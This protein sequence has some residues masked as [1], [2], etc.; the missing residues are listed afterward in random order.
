MSKKTNLQ[1]PRRQVTRQKKRENI[2]RRQRISD[3][4]PATKLRKIEVVDNPEIVIKD[5]PIPK[6]NTQLAEK[7]GTSKCLHP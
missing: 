2:L 3:K 4:K 7:V 6:S 5:S 1:N